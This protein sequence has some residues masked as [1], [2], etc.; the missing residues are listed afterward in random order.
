[1][2]TL[3]KE[4]RSSIMAAVHSKDTT[5]EFLVR[6]YLWAQ[7]IRYRVHLADLPGKPDIV[8][9]RW[10]V[11]VFIHGCF[12]HGHEN[13]QRGRLPKSRTK[14][15]RSKV[16]SNK[17]RDRSIVRKL[18]AEGWRCVVVWECQLRTQRAASITLQLI[19]GQIQSMRAESRIA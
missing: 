16:A 7:G 10:K 1:M 11:A 9:R 3:S 4:K 2:D 15:W 12:W 19:A 6:R 13:C 18:R 14:Y 8:I 17:E 5:T